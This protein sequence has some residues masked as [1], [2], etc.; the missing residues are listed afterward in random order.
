MCR[1]RWNCGRDS[2]SGRIWQGGPGCCSRGTEVMPRS[3]EVWVWVSLRVWLCVGAFSRPAGVTT[4]R[5]FA[6]HT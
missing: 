6:G 3:N 4:A 5:L 1:E 2:A